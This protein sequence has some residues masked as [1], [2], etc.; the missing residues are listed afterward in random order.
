MVN[1]ERFAARQISPTTL[2]VPVS[3]EVAS[4]ETILKACYW[5]SS[6]CVCNVGEPTEGRATVSIE[7]RQGSS[8]S[9]R[10]AGERFQ[11]LLNDFALRERVTHATIGIRDLLLAKAFS[12]AGVL[13]DS[14]QGVFGDPIEEAK[15]DG[16]F[17]I[18][19]N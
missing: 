15:V 17:K 12:E 13:D 6:D 11:S 19:S 10:A 1:E 2:A 8:L 3:L 4:L 16:L 5:L 7:V 14:P 9:L 18:L